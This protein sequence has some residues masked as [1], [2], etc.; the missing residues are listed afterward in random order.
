MGRSDWVAPGTP[1]ET[2]LGR[3]QRQAELD[4]ELSAWSA[5]LSSSELLKR[6]AEAGVPGGRIYTSRDIAADE[7][8]A[9][10]D[11][12]VE[13]PEPALAGETVREPGVVPKLSGTPGR[14]RRGSPLLGEHNDEI[15]AALVGA[16][17]VE[18]LRMEGVV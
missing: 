5:T 4:A 6:L 10:R 8:Y 16:A 14:V 15:L 3:G 9:A 1:Y 12:I 17:E 2:H 7:H 18:R 11:M 13:V